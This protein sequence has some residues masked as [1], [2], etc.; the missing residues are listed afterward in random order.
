MIT[1]PLTG[2]SRCA[3]AVPLCKESREK[4]EDWARSGNNRA[5]ERLL[6]QVE[7]VLRARLRLSIQNREG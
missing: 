4:I 1:V 3:G 2:S 7:A 5:Q 6:H